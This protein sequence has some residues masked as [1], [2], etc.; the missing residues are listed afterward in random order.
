MCK[1]KESIMLVLENSTRDSGTDVSPS[2]LLPS[3]GNRFGKYKKCKLQV[4]RYLPLATT[5]DTDEELVLR[6]QS[7]VMDNTFDSILTKA[8]GEYAT[9]DI[10]A[11]QSNY[12]VQSGI[13]A[14][15]RT[16]ATPL[17]PILLRANP[18]GRMF[19]LTQSTVD[20]DT[21]L[22]RTIYKPAYVPGSS[23]T[24]RDFYCVIRFDFED[25]MT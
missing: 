6:L 23:G 1:E 3:F 11:V 16:M 9:S 21:T 2:W 19:T 10:I 24:A 15:L 14:T 13:P 8:R 22:Q 17:E 12:N 18:L 25:D 7:Y 5:A 4:E 20:F